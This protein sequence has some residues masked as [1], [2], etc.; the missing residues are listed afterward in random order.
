MWARNAENIKQLSGAKKGSKEFIFFTMAQCQF[1]L[2]NETSKPDLSYTRKVRAEGDLENFMATPVQVEGQIQ[3]IPYRHLIVTVHGIRTFGE[4]QDRLEYL[5]K[6]Q[7]PEAQIFHYR[8]GYFSVIAFLIPFL[9]WLVTERFRKA[10]L[11]Q[12]SGPWD[13]IDIVAHSF[14]TH[15]AAWSLLRSKPSERLQVNTLISLV[16]R[17][18]D[19]FEVF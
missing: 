7:E 5:I 2:G 1:M 15:I 6:K 17:R 18:Y 4:W 14:G 16:L 9:R 10:F 8:Y 19:P 3:P 12:V 11:P 13:R